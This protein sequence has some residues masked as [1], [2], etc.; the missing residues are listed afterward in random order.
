[1][2]VWCRNKAAQQPLNHMADLVQTLFLND[3]IFKIGKDFSEKQVRE[4]SGCQ[5]SKWAEAT[6]RGE[7]KR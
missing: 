5:Q 3:D 1:M 4:E 7:R 2:A 6:P